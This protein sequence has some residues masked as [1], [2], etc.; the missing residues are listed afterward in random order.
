MRVYVKKE[1]HVE[2]KVL[3]KNRIIPGKTI[4]PDA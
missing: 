4:P 2:A 3:S 1:H